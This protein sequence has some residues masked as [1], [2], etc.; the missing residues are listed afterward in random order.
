MYSEVIGKGK[1]AGI[2]T[3]SAPSKLIRKLRCLLEMTMAQ[4]TFSMIRDGFGSFNGGEGRRSNLG[5]G[6]GMR[7]GAY[8]S[9]T[10]A[11]IWEPDK[12]AR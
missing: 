6:R 2:L 11:V 7:R 12:R 1:E 9:F 10:S 8:G 4:R 5:T 3:T